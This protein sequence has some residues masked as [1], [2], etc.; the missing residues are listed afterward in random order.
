MSEIDFGIEPL[1]K[2][3]AKKKKA[4]AVKKAV[5]RP[6]GRPLMYPDKTIVRMPKGY[7]KRIN[8]ALKADEGQGDLMRMAVEKEL[9]ARRK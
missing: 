4:K 2:A 1:K 5:K 7:L 3:P 9:K 8:G 6:N